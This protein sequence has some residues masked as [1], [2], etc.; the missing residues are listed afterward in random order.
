M[1]QIGDCYESMKE[2]FPFM[3]KNKLWRGIS[4]HKWI[5]LATFIISLL[6]TYI[7]FLN[8]LEY[9]SIDPVEARSLN[10]NLEDEIGEEKMDKLK[11]AGK[12]TL[13]TGG[14]KN[15]F[16]ILSEVIIFFFA[17][18]ALAT[19]KGIKISP[20]FKQFM[21]AQKRMILVMVRNFIKA[22]IISIPIHIIFGIL[23]IHEHVGKVMFFVYAYYIGLAFLDNYSEQ[24]EIPIDESCQR[25]YVH[26]Y[27][28]TFLGVVISIFLYIPFIG[29]L[30]TPLFGAIA[31]TLYGH[32]NS[33]EHLE[34]EEIF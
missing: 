27:A 11:A 6:I 7:L 16:L 12:A 20:T 26:R 29:P 21:K 8:C 9:F 30:I 5:A 17:T 4:Q 18:K 3:K 13:L 31:A 33:L 22:I 19:I 23:S 2:V 14:W 15:L 34:P 10:L 32:K 24:F 1:Y 28:S 25:I